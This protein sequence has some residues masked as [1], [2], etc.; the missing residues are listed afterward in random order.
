V[1]GEYIRNHTQHSDKIYVWG[2]VPGI[3]LSA[4]RFCPSPAAFESEM[5]TMPP[6]QLEQLIDELLSYFSKDMPKYIV[7][8]RKQHLPLDRAK[9]E[10]WPIVGYSSQGQPKFLP[11][12]PQMVAEFEKQWAQMTRERFGEDETRRFEIMGKFRKFI[13]EN[14]DIAQM[15][16]DCVIFKLK[17][18]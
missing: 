13:R 16:G 4:Q 7:D 14:Y 8:S 11:S 1:T 18:K 9:F 10:L 12:D 3:Y 15:F 6:E 5:H 17:K 2:W